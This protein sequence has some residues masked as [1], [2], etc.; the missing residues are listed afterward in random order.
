MGTASMNFDLLYCIGKNYRIDNPNGT[1]ILISNINSTLTTTQW[2]GVY[3]ELT[4]AIMTLSFVH[5]KL[6][7]IC[8]LGWSL[9][10]LF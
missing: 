8:S 10:S 4:V 5:D 3:G 6:Q 7:Y 1:N 2:V 9:F